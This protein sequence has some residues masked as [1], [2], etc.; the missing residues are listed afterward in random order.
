VN[1]K[2]NYST[3][4]QKEVQTIHNEMTITETI[5]FFIAEDKI[6]F[7]SKANETNTIK[8]LTSNIKTYGF[9]QNKPL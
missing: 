4:F 2:N 6:Y 7:C 8:L 3:T 5:I 1:G 9:L